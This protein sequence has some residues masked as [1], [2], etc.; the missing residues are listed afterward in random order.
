[1]APV[2]PVPQIKALECPSCGGTVQLRGHGHTVSAVCTQ[3]LSILD[4]RSPSLEIIQKAAGSERFQPLI[5]LGTRGK[6]DNIEWEAIGFQVRQIVVEGIAYRWSEYL[7]YNPYRGYRYLTEYRGHWNC[8]RGV[9]SLPSP[10][11]KQGRRA[12]VLA[13]QTYAHFQA[14]RAETIYVIGEFPWRATVG[15][16]VSVD[17][18]V[19][20]PFVLSSETTQDEVVWSSGA[21]RPGRD[22]WQAFQLSGNPPPPEGVYANQPSPWKGKVGGTWWTFALLTFAF[23]LVSVIMGIFGRGSE[24]FRAPYS[25]DSS[26]KGEQAFVTPVFDLKGGNVAVRVDTDLSNDWAFFSLALIN[27]ETGTA[28]DFGREVSYYS[29]RDSDGDWSEG[30]RYGSTTVPA[31]PAGRYYLRVEPDMDDSGT[32]RMQYT[33]SVKQGVMGWLWLIVAFFLLPL[34]AIWRSWQYGR[35]EQQRWAESDYSGG[36]DEEDE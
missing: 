28:F 21:Y 13:G 32:H 30:N 2:T 25:F 24:V 6:L 33:I 17:D 14:A 22:I 23:L 18:Y 12:F 8:I 5:P 36:S 27:E 3:C 20:P 29:G 4:T 34:P 35:F 16:A 11:T 1:M 15:E 9:R 7:L 10:T 19:S 26:Q 31:V